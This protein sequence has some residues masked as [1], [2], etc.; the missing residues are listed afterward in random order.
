MD[1]DV[2]LGTKLTQLQVQEQVDVS[3]GTPPDYEGRIAVDP[4]LMDVGRLV[5]ALET[6]GFEL[7]NTQVHQNLVLHH[8]GSS[9]HHSTILLRKA[10]H[11]VGSPFR[12][13][14]LQEISWRDLQWMKMEQ[15]GSPVPVWEEVVVDEVTG[16]VTTVVLPNQVESSDEGSKESMSLAN[17]S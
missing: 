16:V 9:M 14:M 2:G 8:L 1:R 10:C 15:R 13:A 12:P 4:I 3:S 6:G 11:M 5:E 17:I 7:M